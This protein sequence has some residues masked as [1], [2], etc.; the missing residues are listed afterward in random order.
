M[1]K[2][3]DQIID[4]IQRLFDF[5]VNIIKALRTAIVVLTSAVQF[6]L[7]LVGYLPVILG[8]CIVVVVAVGAVKFIIGR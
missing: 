1:F 5:L 7:G 3:F 4:Y 2:F 8:S 6:P